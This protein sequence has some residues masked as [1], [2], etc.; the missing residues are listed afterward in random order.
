ME[1][2]SHLEKRTLL[3]DLLQE[4]CRWE[5]GRRKGSR[6]SRSRTAA[7]RSSS[8]HPG[9]KVRVN[10]LK[11][12]WSW[13]KKE[14]CFEIGRIRGRWT[15]LKDKMDLTN[16]WWEDP[17]WDSMLSDPKNP[18]HSQLPLVP[19][20]LL[21]GHISTNHFDSHQR[22]ERNSDDDDDDDLQQRR[23]HQTPTSRWGSCR[24]RTQI[25]QLSPSRTSTSW[26][27][28]IITIVID[29]YWEKKGNVK[30]NERLVSQTNVRLCFF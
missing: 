18:V 27:S 7:C 4:C 28:N 9:K 19:D 10:E 20:Q 6:G 22:R 24:V 15:V 23:H 12:K 8:L 29:K 17:E 3:Q 5:A 16:I 2:L 1:C 11:C 30:I 13:G 26:I 14:G 21:W 25:L